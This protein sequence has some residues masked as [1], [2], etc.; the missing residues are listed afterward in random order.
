MA[1]RANRA[2]AVRPGWA[3]ISSIAVRAAARPSIARRNTRAWRGSAHTAQSR[4]RIV[5]ARL[6]SLRRAEVIIMAS[7]P[8]NPAAQDNLACDRS[9]ARLVSL[10]HLA[11]TLRGVSM[12]G[13]ERPWTTTTGSSR[14]QLGVDSAPARRQGV[15]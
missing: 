15:G 14:N 3:W 4:M 5:R 1:R 13:G 8:P 11:A 7:R 10:I 12:T 9:Y 2:R 6:L